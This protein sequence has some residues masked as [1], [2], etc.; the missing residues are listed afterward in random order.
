[1]SGVLKIQKTNS[2]LQLKSTNVSQTVT[3][4]ENIYH[5]SVLF[6]DKDTLTTGY[7]R[8]SWYTSGDYG[9]AI[10]CKRVINNSEVENI[11]TLILSNTGE[12]S[13]SIS[14]SSAWRDALGI[15]NTVTTID[16][17]S[18][19]NVPSATDTSLLNTGLL[20]AGTYILRYEA[21]FTTNATGRRHIHLSTTS[22]GASIN[23][24]NG[25]TIPAVSGATTQIASVYLVTITS[26]TTYYLT[27]HQ[28]SGSTLTVGGGMRILKIH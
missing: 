1:M 5:P 3:P 18:D 15:N 8:N 11:L 28:N 7:L 10:G 24:H 26:A 19:I 27:V 22:G 4:T 2:Q 25:V 9:T 16:T 12:R 14:D 13:I 23:R 6:Q 17:S 21:N 20:T